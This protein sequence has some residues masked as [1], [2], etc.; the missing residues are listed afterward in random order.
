MFYFPVIA[1]LK[2]E[3][4]DWMNNTVSFF[5]KKTGVPVL[6]HLGP[7]VLNLLKDLPAEE[8]LFSYL[9][10][11]R[12]GDRATEFG[13]RCR[14]LGIKGVSLHSYRYAWAGRARAA[15]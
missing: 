12:P 8:P 2:G 14:R 3:N 15:G 4:V 7:E 11:V 6:V 10:S 9:A 1:L 13:Q 5:R